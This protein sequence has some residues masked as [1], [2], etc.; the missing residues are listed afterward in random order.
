MPTV[1][2]YHFSCGISLIW[3]V[4]EYRRHA[5]ATSLIQ[6]VRDCFVRPTHLSMDDV[7]FINPNNEAGGLARKLANRRDVLVANTMQVE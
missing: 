1:N 6:A 4:A 7:A 3:V 2:F 5:V